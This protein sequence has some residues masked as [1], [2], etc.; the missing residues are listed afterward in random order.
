[1]PIPISES[2]YQYC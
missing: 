1:M 2:T